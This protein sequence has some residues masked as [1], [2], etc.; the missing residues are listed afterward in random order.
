MVPRSRLYQFAEVELAHSHSAHELR[1]AIERNDSA[2][3]LAITIEGGRDSSSVFSL[4]HMD[5]KYE[6]AAGEIT[7]S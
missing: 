1:H 6:I 3:A 2:V 7:L 4:S 5:D